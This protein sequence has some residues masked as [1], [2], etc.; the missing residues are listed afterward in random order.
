[1]VMNKSDYVIK[2]LELINDETTYRKF[3]TSF[4]QHKATEFKKEERKI[5]TKSESVKP[6]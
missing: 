5:L 2:M 6:L 1:M 3:L 4:A